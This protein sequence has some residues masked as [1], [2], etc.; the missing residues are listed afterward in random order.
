MVKLA[1]FT[2][3]S[4]LVGSLVAP[5]GVLAA[6][7]PNVQFQNNQTTVEGTGGSTVTATFRVIV[8]ANE[9]VEYIQTDVVGDSL[10]PVCTSIGGELGLQQGTHD[11]SLPIKLP[12]NT[13]THTLEVQGSGIYGGFRADDCVGD[14]VG[15]ASFG[16]A[17][18]VVSSSSTSSNSNT[19]S[20]WTNM[21]FEQLIAALVLALKNAGIGSPPPAPVVSAK[22]AMLNEKMIGTQYGV[23][24][25]ANVMLQGFLLSEGQSIPA[26]TQGAAFGFYGSQTAS[27]LASFRAINGCN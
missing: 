22:C 8:G 16:S 21:S 14:V 18:R 4:L 12:Q 1:K 20:S 24:N 9:V 11:V 7:F 26:L 19:S 2:A 10:A 13:G 23:R 15:S 5:L 17:L 25:N 27:A 6:S 3:V